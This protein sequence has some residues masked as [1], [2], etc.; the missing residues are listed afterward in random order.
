[1]VGVASEAG[2]SDS[3][4]GMALTDACSGIACFVRCFEKLEKAAVEGFRAKY[5]QP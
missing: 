2:C 4:L 3:K 5:L 1:M